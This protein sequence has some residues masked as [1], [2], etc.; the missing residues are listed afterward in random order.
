[1]TKG[2]ILVAD[3]DMAIRTVINHALS[4]AGYEVKLVSN[5]A[6]LWDCINK[7]IVDVIVTDVV[8]PDENTFN[9]IPKIKQ[10]KPNV[11]IIVMSAKNTLMT[12]ITAAEKGAFEYLPKPFDLNELLNII[13]RAIKEKEA[14]KTKTKPLIEHEIIPLIGRSQAMQEIYRTMARLTQIDLTVMITGESGTGKELI[15]RA[16]H[17]FGKRKNGT[18]VA[19]NMAAIPKDLIESELFGHEKGS[20]TGAINRSIGKFELAHNGTLFLDEIG[21][22]P[23]EAQ[24]R[25]LRVLQQ[26]EFITVGGNKPIKTNVRIIAATHRLLTQQIQQGLFR[27]DLYYRLNVVPINIPPL[28]DRKEDIPLLVK[29]FMQKDLSEGIEQ[30]DIDDNALEQLQHYDWPGNVRELENL[31][32]RIMALYSHELITLDIIEAELIKMKNAVKII[33]N[34]NFNLNDSIDKFLNNFSIDDIDKLPNGLYDKI[35]ETFERPLIA[36]I[37]SLTKGNQIKAAKLL[38]VNRN[39]L[40]KKIRELSVPVFKAN[41]N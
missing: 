39:T 18:F 33:T 2:T 36:Y 11:P 9:L 23:L 15:A 29:Y 35:L 7:E 41:K 38:G 3:D 37:L 30:K 5:A 27:E 1:M 25:L 32:N 19:I 8:M 22:M 14:K 20:F 10:L 24:T 40:R 16:L 17:E 21:D 13:A 31:I 34:E 6:T 26:G 4:R 28:R 12:A